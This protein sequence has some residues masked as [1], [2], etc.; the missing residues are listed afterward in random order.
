MKNPADMIAIANAMKKFQADHPK[1]V[2]FFQNEILS[3]VPEGT[4]IE[5]SVE[6]PG[7]AKVTSNLK[8][9]A[10]DLAAFEKLKNM[11]P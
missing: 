2:A 8:V 11:K 3:G 10:D 1:A 5:F 9:N 4:I 6:K 7:G